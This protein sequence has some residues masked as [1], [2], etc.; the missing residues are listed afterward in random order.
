MPH[1]DVK[2]GIR[3]GVD[4]NE[5]PVGWQWEV[6]RTFRDDQGAVLGE[7]RVTVPL[8]AEE[9]SE[10]VSAALVA[11]AADIARD[12]AVRDKAVADCK[13]AEAARDQAVAERDALAQKLA[14][15]RAALR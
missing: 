4:K 9:L 13:A 1:T 3:A 7:A 11:Q 8:T 6:L 2:T 14:D 5:V 12:S 10:H 15:A